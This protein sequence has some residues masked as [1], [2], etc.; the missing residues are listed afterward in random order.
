M[1]G[2]RS[3]ARHKHTHSD[4]VNTSCKAQGRI[5]VH[6]IGHAERR[7]QPP[8]AWSTLVTHS[9]PCHLHG[10]PML[11][12]GASPRRQVCGCVCARTCVC[13]CARACKVCARCVCV[14]V[15]VCAC[16]TGA[17]CLYMSVGRGRGGL[18][19]CAGVAV[20]VGRVDGVWVDVFRD[21]PLVG[22]VPDHVASLPCSPT[23]AVAMHGL[24]TC[25]TT[26]N[27]SPICVWR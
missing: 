8:L 18:R 2:W 14:C 24:V 16:K 6:R 27:I 7:T 26:C 23:V 10:T 9:I 20:P 25:F 19:G 11:R 17:L 12:E 5:L 4:A 3:R 13:M 1:E 15:C 22:R 21:M